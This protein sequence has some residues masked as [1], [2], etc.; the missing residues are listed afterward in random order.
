MSDQ[1]EVRRST[2]AIRGSDTFGILGSAVAAI[3]LAAWLTSQLLIFQGFLPFIGFA[4][5]FFII[6][7]G[8]V[9]R[10]DETGMVVQ[11]MTSKLV[12][13]RRPTTSSAA[14]NH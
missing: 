12:A 8:I 5:L 14:N 13:S 9:T 10:F 6:F 2:G 3:S 11:V 1:V 7:Y 4:Y